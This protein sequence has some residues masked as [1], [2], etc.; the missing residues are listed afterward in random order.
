MNDGTNIY[1][2]KIYNSEFLKIK[3]LIYLEVQ[4][5]KAFRPLYFCAAF[6][7]SEDQIGVTKV[8]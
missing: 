7:S 2:K 3:K 1:P 8:F 4:D 5:Y 6:T